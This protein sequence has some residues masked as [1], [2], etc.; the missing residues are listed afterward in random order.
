MHGDFSYSIY[1]LTL[2]GMKEESQPCP[3]CGKIF[4][5]K[6]SLEP[7]ILMVHKGV[8]KKCPDCGKILSDLWKHMRTIHGHYRR[9]VKIPKEEAILQLS[10]DGIS[11]EN[12][13]N[14]ELQTNIVST[15][16]SALSQSP[17]S[18]PLSSK[19]LINQG[20]TVIPKSFNNSKQRE[21]LAQNNAIVKSKAG[22][23][24]LDANKS[25]PNENNKTPKQKSVEEKQGVPK[26]VQ[27]D[28]GG[29]PKHHKTSTSLA[30]AKNK[31]KN[32]LPLKVKLSFKFGKKSSDGG[33]SNRKPTMRLSDND[34]D[35][36][37]L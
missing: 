19:K 30:S 11:I 23:S 2:L 22:H 14:P 29:I 1:I 34:D 37:D 18:S 13:E 26:Q 6:S 15:P 28:D 27:G 35:D 31:R 8:R 25:I 24:K 10:S 12:N 3:H 21:K 9:R 7:H 5:T 33:S 4:S 17:L 36:V 16:G 32:S 20:T